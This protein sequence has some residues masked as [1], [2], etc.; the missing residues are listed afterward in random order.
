[1]EIINKEF[2]DKIL[3]QNP[4]LKKEIISINKDIEIKKEIKKEEKNDISKYMPYVLGGI[5]ILFVGGR[6]LYKKYKDK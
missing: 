1:M 5:V 2:S 6:Y 4:E 3:K